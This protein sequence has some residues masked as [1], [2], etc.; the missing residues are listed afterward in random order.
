M[1]DLPALFII[2]AVFFVSSVALIFYSKTGPM[3]VMPVQN[4]WTIVQEAES[5][6][7]D[8]A[9]NV[10]A[11]RDYEQLFEP[12]Y[13]LTLRRFENIVLQE[14]LIARYVAIITPIHSLPSQASFAPSGFEV[15]FVDSN[16]AGYVGEI[17]II[18]LVKFG[19]QP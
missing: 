2:L 9:W 13:K 5:R 6:L 15:G 11:G 10:S 1:K 17:S 12:N 14:K 4:A 8:R 16:P 19:M 7:E 18:G 3:P